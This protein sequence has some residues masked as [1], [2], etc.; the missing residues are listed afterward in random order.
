M[1]GCK[2]VDFPTSFR[3]RATE[4][5]QAEAAWPHRWGK[6]IG[7]KQQPPDSGLLANCIQSDDL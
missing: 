7:T 6:P 4:L 2:Y 5:K 1:P 3:E